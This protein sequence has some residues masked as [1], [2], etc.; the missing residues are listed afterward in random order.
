MSDYTDYVRG[1]DGPAPRGESLNKGPVAGIQNLSGGVIRFSVAPTDP[2]AYVETRHQEANRSNVGTV[3]RTGGDGQVTATPTRMEVSVSSLTGNN[4]GILATARNGH[5]SPT[6]N[7]TANSIVEYRGTTVKVS[8]LETMGILEK[9]PDGRYVEAGTSTGYAPAQAPLVSNHP[10][11]QQREYQQQAQAQQVT[12]ES[13]IAEEFP[14]EIADVVAK[15]IAPIPPQL[16]QATLAKMLEG[17]M[18]DRDYREIAKLSGISEKD[19]RERATFVDNA[20]K[21]QADNIAHRAGINDAAELWQWATEEKYEA[22]HKARQELIFGRNVAPLQALANEYFR[23]NVPT[24]EALR[25][26]GY[27]VE[28]TPAGHDVVMINGR[29]ITPATAAKLGLV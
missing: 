3:Y 21:A 24:I 14:R 4:G 5:G 28:K 18:N 19:A 6:S 17:N 22:L 12:A 10:Q 13:F 25:N 26:A 27:E 8:T 11:I 23:S 15:A 7:V 2:G 1:S 16:Y 9:T 29:W 20:F